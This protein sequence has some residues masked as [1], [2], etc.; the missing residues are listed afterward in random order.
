M[1]RYQG[2]PLPKGSRIAVISNDALGNYVVVTPLLQML[3][4]QHQPERLDYFGGARTRELWE[5]D[6]N[7]DRGFPL[8]GSRPADAARALSGRYD[9]VINVE[10]MPWAKCFAAMAAEGGFVCG[11]SLDAEGRRDLAWADDDRGRLWADQEWISPALTER[12]PFLESAFIGEIFCRLAYL[13]GPVPSYSVPRRP[14]NT[15]VPSV[16]IATAASLEDKLWPKERWAEVLRWLRGQ[17]YEAGLLGAPPRVQKQY[18]QGEAWEEELIRDGLV[19]DLRGALSLPQV[20]G[21]LAQAKAVLTLDNGILHLAVAA[22]SRT[23][24]LFRHGIH[25]LWAPPSPL[26]EQCVAAEG[27]AVAQ[28][29]TEEVR[30][31]LRLAL[32]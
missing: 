10:W 26:L 28:I 27:G 25:R 12:Y 29:S 30:E 7:I 6:P 22:G 24:G 5:A 21:A 11:P 32:A 18:W 15:E 16:L 4:A 1:R 19:Q 14:A 13:E 3:R 20:V 2:E 31:A 23:V 17:G 8:F 9:L